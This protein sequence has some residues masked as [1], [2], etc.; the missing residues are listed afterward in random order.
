M[1]RMFLLFALSALCCLCLPLAVQGQ[2]YVITEAELIRLESI[3][4]SLAISRQNLQSQAS[5]LAER[6]RAQESKAKTLAVSLQQAEKTANTLNNQLQ[7]ERDTLKNLRTSYNK[8]EQEA[9]ETIAEKQA[10]IDEKKDTIHRLT[11]TVIMLSTALVGAIVFAIVKL[12][13]FFPFLP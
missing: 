4:Q 12:K 7:T 3:S 9:A 1:K 6:L 13:R 8:S 5:D 10:L 11:I 2:E